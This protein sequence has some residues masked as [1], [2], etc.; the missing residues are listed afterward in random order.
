MTG[1]FGVSAFFHALLVGLV[2]LFTVVLRDREKPEE[3]PF[4]L[5][6]GPGDNFM[7]EEATAGSEAG[8]ARTNEID[9]TP[10][11][12]PVWTPP[13]PVQEI[14]PPE[15]TP[16]T[17]VV[18]LPPEPVKKV[19]SPPVPNF[20][21]QINRTLQQEKRKTERELKKQRDKDEREAKE[22]ELASKRLTHEEYLKSLKSPSQRSSTKSTS[23]GPRLDP[24]AIRRG[25]ENAT[26][27]G[28]GAGGPALSAAAEGA[29]MERY[30][31][32]LRSRLRENH[33]KPGGLSDLLNAEV[34]FTLG[35][36]GSISGVRI[37]RSSG[38]ADFDQSVTEAFARVRMPA[39]PDGK[40]DSIRLVFRMK[41]I[42]GR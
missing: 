23:P 4:E 40:S 41:E 9:F 8:Q 12:V 22:R 28:P 37:V 36:D 33:E 30:F 13:V 5:V 15:Q 21:N 24:N 11:E 27:A 2:V 7:A 20:K 29:A 3:K 34:Q 18:P 35:A 42:E 16:P 31:S 1:A 26:G 14:S 10:P 25:M 19:V 32:M 6:G 39:R 17:P 38:N